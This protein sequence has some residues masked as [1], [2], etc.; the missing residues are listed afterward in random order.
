MKE[1]VSKRDEI[2]H[3]DKQHVRIFVHERN[4]NENIARLGI[5]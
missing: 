2:L 3:F 5:N 4:H 1:L